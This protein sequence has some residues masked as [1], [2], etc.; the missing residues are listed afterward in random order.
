MIG[1]KICPECGSDEVEIVGKGHMGIWT[2]RECGF[3]AN[4][5]PE[6]PVI[7]IH[8]ENFV[9]ETDE[10]FDD[11]PIKKKYNKGVKKKRL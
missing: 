8:Q 5:F 10:D 11:E 9:A 4:D 2:C 7:G 3:S 6:K 1:K